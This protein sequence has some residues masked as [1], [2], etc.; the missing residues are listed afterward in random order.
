MRNLPLISVIVPVYNVEAYLDRCVQSIVNQTYQNLEIILVDDGSPDRCPAMC[1]SWAA[2]DSRIRVIHQPNAGSGAARNAA[3]DI[4]QGELIGFADSDDYLEPTM[5]SHL[6]ELIYRY[7]AD[8][9]ECAYVLVTGDVASFDVTSDTIQTYSVHDA[10]YEHICN[11]V[12]QQVIWNKL[13]RRN[14]IGD[15]RFPAS[16][17]I[18]DEFFT[19]RVIGNAQI[20]VRSE[21]T[22]YAYCQQ[23]DSIMHTTPVLDCFSGVD[24]KICRHEYIMAHFP[25]LEGIS[26]KSVIINCLYLNQL[27]MCGN[28]CK[29]KKTLLDN[30]TEILK[31]YPLKRHILLSMTLKE[32]FWLIMATWNMALTCQ[33][34]NLLR[35]GL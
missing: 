23:S 2:K 6:F 5:F 4:A 19:Y 8:I 25:K 35:I 17:K 12:F 1:D 16:K 28:D 34:R 27:A 18:D 21:K 10:M 14:V 7:D 32:R 9:S 11:H 20:L 15:I 33:I 13:Y 22:C 31:T 26:Y 3:L 29:T 30:T 24:A